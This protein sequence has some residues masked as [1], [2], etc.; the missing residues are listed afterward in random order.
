MERA[1]KFIRGLGLPDGAISP[2]EIACAAWA[3]AVG[4]KIAKRTRAIRMVRSRLIVEVEDSVWQR[5][6]FTLS[7]H[8]LRNLEK[9]LGPGVVEDLEFRVVPRRRGP[10]RAEQPASKSIDE[11]AGIDDPVL[12]I[13]YKAARQKALA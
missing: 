2:E 11:A 7:F 13:L 4:P 8:I 12:R 5:Q 3:H 1:S 10:Q 9:N 6:L